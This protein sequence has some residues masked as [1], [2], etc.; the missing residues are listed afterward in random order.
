MDTKNQLVLCL[1]K[2]CLA[3]SNCIYFRT[4]FT[5]SGISNFSKDLTRAYIPLLADNLAFT[6][7]HYACKGRI[8]LSNSERIGKLQVS[9]VTCGWCPIQYVVAFMIRGWLREEMHVPIDI[10]SAVTKSIPHVKYNLS[11]IPNQSKSILSLELSNCIDGQ[12]IWRCNMHQI[13]YMISEI[14]HYL[15]FI[16]Q[17]LDYQE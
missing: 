11:D 17:D 2:K 13:D 6:I 8:S 12:G 3:V 9:R 4:I 16:F 14:C 7:I 10:G 15:I 5:C 1:R